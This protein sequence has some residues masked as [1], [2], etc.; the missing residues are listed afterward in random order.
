MP[1][2][3]SLRNGF[4][5]CNLQ[6]VVAVISDWVVALEAIPEW[7]PADAKQDPMVLITDL[8]HINE[9]KLHSLVC[10]ITTH[11]TSPQ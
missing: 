9:T 4:A 6:A 8:L 1:I 10:A 7:E 11:L 3:E 2:L 5:N